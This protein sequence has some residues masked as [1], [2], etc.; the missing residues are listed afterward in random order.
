[1]SD[2]KANY[3]WDRST[4]SPSSGGYPVAADVSVRDLE[5]LQPYQG[6]HPSNYIH[7]RVDILNRL[8]EIEGLLEGDDDPIVRLHL[9]QE[10]L[11]L[12]NRLYE[13]TI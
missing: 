6:G 9:Q 5:P 3:S 1:M 4:G 8:I 12:E 13:S 7:S 11:N 10:R 2:I